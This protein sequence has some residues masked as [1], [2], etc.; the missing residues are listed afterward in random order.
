MGT[1]DAFLPVEWLGHR[2]GG[3]G[4]ARLL[5]L[6][7][8]GNGTGPA[9]SVSKRECQWRPPSRWQAPGAHSWATAEW[10]PQRPTCEHGVNPNLVMLIA[11]KASLPGCHP[12]NPS[13]SMSIAKKLHSLE[14]KDADCC[15]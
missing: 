2:D 3:R 5:S 4:E 7:P 10:V 13:L 14:K 1:P 8:P 11:Q 6:Q 15:N 12:A 9:R